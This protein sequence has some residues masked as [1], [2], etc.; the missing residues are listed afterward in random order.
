M[1]YTETID[2]MKNMSTKEKIGKNGLLNLINEWFFNKP[3]Q[4]LVGEII[5][6]YK[7]K[8]RITSPN[9]IGYNALKLIVFETLYDKSDPQYVFVRPS[10]GYQLMNGDLK[11]AMAI[12]MIALG[13]AELCSILE[14]WQEFSPKELTDYLEKL[15]LSGII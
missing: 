8:I 11:E 13:V 2:V 7:W 10:I 5:E 6:Y 12:N 14:C 4:N 9:E 1:T 15:K 3:T